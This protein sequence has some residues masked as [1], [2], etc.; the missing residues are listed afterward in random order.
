MRLIL[1]WIINTLAILAITKLLP[2]I[3]IEALW[4]AV[5]AALVLGLLN[6]FVRPI[7]VVATLPLNV[8]T[9]GLF[10]LVLNGLILQ[11]IDWIMGS[12]MSIANFGWAILGALLISIITGAINIIVGGDRRIDRSRR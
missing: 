8:L 4:V 3:Q 12:R 1:R 11:I 5:V 10:T 6:T 2:A 9:L 7:L